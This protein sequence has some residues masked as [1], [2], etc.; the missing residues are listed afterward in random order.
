MATNEPSAEASL[1]DETYSSIEQGPPPGWKESTPIGYM[2]S[3]MSFP[4]TSSLSKTDLSPIQPSLD[5]SYFGNMIKFHEKQ[6]QD[7]KNMQV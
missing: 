4:G 5:E 7:L 2:D 3:P 6:L 1:L